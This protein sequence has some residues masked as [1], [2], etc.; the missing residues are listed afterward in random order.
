MALA[1]FI[2]IHAPSYHSCTSQAAVPKQWFM[3][4]YEYGCEILSSAML[5]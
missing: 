3:L 5:L 1:V 4:N 2:Y